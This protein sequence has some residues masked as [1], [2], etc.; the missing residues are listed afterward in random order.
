MSVLSALYVGTVLRRDHDSG[1]RHDMG[2]HG[3]SHPVRKHRRFV[4]GRCRL[5]SGGGLRLSDLKG[6]ALRQYDAYRY[7]LVDAQLNLHL[8]VKILGLIP[9]DVLR[10]GNLIVIF[11]V[12]E[13]E[14]VAILVEELEFAFLHKGPLDLIG[15][16]VALR[17]LHAIAQSSHIYL[18]NW[19]SLAWVDVF[20]GQDH[21]EPAVE[22]DDVSLAERAGDD[23]HRRNPSINKKP[24]G[25][26]G[27][28]LGALGRI[29]GPQ[30]T[31]P[32]SWRQHFRRTHAVEIRRAARGGRGVGPHAATFAVVDA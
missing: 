29:R 20:G 25:Q 13:M 10:D 17:G 12:H 32:A 15:G 5:T 2:R 8:R 28:R 22:V 14:A 24:G 11:H 19:R 4:G 30:H 27:G 16:L 23:F 26:P 7:A 6:H 1:A 21:I 3:G 9:D 31:D 18:G